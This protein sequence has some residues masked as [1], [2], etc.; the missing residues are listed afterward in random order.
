MKIGSGSRSESRKP[1]GSTWPQTAPVS[2]VVLQPEPARYPR[3]THSI[4]SMSKLAADHRAPVGSQLEQVVRD[5][6]LVRENQKAE[7]PVRT[8]PLSGIGVRQDDVEGRDPVACDEQQPIVVQREDLA[9]LAACDV[10]RLRH[11]DLLLG[12]VASQSLEDDIRMP[13][14]GIEVEDLVE[15]HARC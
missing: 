14:E 2:L 9:H 8:R 5:D 3:T 6:L 7:R 10:N 15:G 12:R 11:D 1:S 4:G 13:G